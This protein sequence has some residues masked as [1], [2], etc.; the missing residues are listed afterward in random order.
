M[1]TKILKQ[2]FAAVSTESTLV[3]KGTPTRWRRS[4]HLF[5]CLQ[6]SPQGTFN[7]MSEHDLLALLNMIPVK[8]YSVV[9]YYE[10]Q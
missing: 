9:I 7:I 3:F 2:P 8:Y 5:V 1:G 4:H 10:G 6:K